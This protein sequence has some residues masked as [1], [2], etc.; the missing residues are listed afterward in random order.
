MH[1]KTNILNDEEGA[2]TVMDAAIALSL[3]VILT[4][5]FFTAAQNVHDPYEKTSINA[6]AIDIFETITNLPGLAG[7]NESN[8]WENDTLNVSR[9]GLGTDDLLMY[10]MAK[11]DGNGEI[12]EVLSRYKPSWSDYYWDEWT[13]F[14]AGTKVI[15]ADGSQK[16]IENI[17]IGDFVKSYDKNTGLVVPGE[18]SEVFYHSPEEMSDFYVIINGYLKVTSNHLLYSERDICDCGEYEGSWIKASELEVGDILFN[19]EGGYYISSIEWVYEKVITYNF[20][21]EEYHNY[22]VAMDTNDDIG[23][24]V[25]NDDPWIPEGCFPY[26]GGEPCYPTD[27]YFT[28][29]I[30]N[31][32]NDLIPSFTWYD[33]DGDDYRSRVMINDSGAICGPI[34]RLNIYGSMYNFGNSSQIISFWDFNYSESEGFRPSYSRALF[35][36]YKNR[37][38]PFMYDLETGPNSVAMQIGLRHKD[39]GGGYKRRA[40]SMSDTLYIQTVY[41]YYDQPPHAEFIAADVDDWGA[42]LTVG[43]DA[44]L[45]YDDNTSILNTLNSKI[46]KVEW[47]WDLE[48]ED[49]DNFHANEWYIESNMSGD[50]IYYH[51]YSDRIQHLAA[52]RVTDGIGQTTIFTDRVYG[53]FKSQMVDFAWWDIDGHGP[54]KTFFFDANVSDSHE[55]IKHYYW[56]FDGAGNSGGT[57]GCYQSPNPSPPPEIP[58]CEYANITFEY[59]ADDPAPH[60][61]YLF[62]QYDFGF[63]L[64]H[65]VKHVQEWPEPQ[66][67]WSDADGDGS[68]TIITFDPSKSLEFDIPNPPNVKVTAWDYDFDVPSPKYY[69]QNLTAAEIVTFMGNSDDWGLGNP[70]NVTHNYGDY[71]TYNA[72]MMITDQRGN[73]YVVNQ[74]VQAF[75]DPEPI[76]MFVYNS[77]IGETQI[78]FDASQSVDYTGPLDSTA[79]Y[80]NDSAAIKKYEWD[81][82]GDGIFEETY[83]YPNYKVMHDYGDFDWHEVTLKVWEHPTLRYPDGRNDTFTL[84]VTANETANALFTWYDKDGIGPDA[85]ITFNSSESWWLCGVIGLYLWDWDGDF[86]IRYIGYN[87]ADPSYGATNE[88]QIDHDF[89]LDNDTKANPYAKYWTGL[90]LWGYGFRSGLYDNVD[91][92]H[93]WVEAYQPEFSWSNGVDKT[94]HFDAS[95]SWDYFDDYDVNW[96]I[97]RIEWDW[98]LQGSNP[99]NFHADE[100]YNATNLTEGKT[101]NHNWGNINPHVVALRLWDENDTLS[102]VV[103]ETVT[104]TESPTFT[105]GFN[106]E[107][108]DGDGFGT[109]IDFSAYTNIGEWNEKK[110]GVNFT[111]D[112]TSD[113]DWDLTTPNRTVSYTYDSPDPHIVTL[114]INTSYHFVIIRDTVQASVYPEN[115]P[116]LSDDEDD[117]WNGVLTSKNDQLPD[118]PDTYIVFNQVNDTNYSYMIYKEKSSENL[119]LD[120]E[121]IQSLSDVPYEKFLESL[122]L[123]SYSFGIGIEISWYDDITNTNEIIRYGISPDCE[124][125]GSTFTKKAVIMKKPVFNSLWSVI[126]AH[127]FEGTITLKVIE[128]TMP[129]D[130]QNKP[131]EKPTTISPVDND[132]N[133]PLETQL[134]VDVIDPDGDDMTVNFYNAIDHSLF[135]TVLETPSETTA[136]ISVKNLENG[137]LY[138]WYVTID[139]GSYI[140]TSEIWSFTTV[141]FIENE[142]PSTPAI[143]TG[144]EYLQPNDNAPYFTSAVDP[145]NG[146]TVYYKFDWGDGSTSEWTTA[147]TV[148][149]SW[150]TGGTYTVKAM[151]KDDSEAESDWSDGLTVTV[152]SPPSQPTLKEPTNHLVGVDINTLTF[153]WDDCE[154]PEGN[155][156]TYM[157][158]LSEQNPPVY[159]KDVGGSEYSIKSP[160][161]PNTH[162][163]WKVVARDTH[164]A[165]SE[166]SVIWDFITKT[167]KK[168]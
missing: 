150:D 146:D 121:K 104:P 131:P 68:G 91:I 120:L 29:V 47:D 63:S 100:W 64:N 109:T 85:I 34:W 166:P 44:S 48:D 145:N 122:G 4:L 74:T 14:L 6:V 116:W 57:Y 108:A 133:I 12:E 143:P 19:L 92:G 96:T 147:E 65:I 50:G 106:W 117:Q 42:D 149:N 25:H 46:V 7:D 45:S 168:L 20:E 94:V 9:I 90:T 24:L 73:A 119:I 111:W 123:D 39:A 33:I 53:L 83:N 118:D 49:P 2:A 3:S 89:S 97:S 124:A 135:G 110:H 138:N 113:G 103:Y 56:D 163:Y 1:K 8:N 43:F 72:A 101:P 54:G 99:A 127:R 40:W 129:T 157:L 132:N 98:D 112:W 31:Y 41:G 78:Y 59:N 28:G 130:S 105:G 81:F 62:I 55:N 128:W 125:E 159:W 77:T 114:K 151:A 137:A 95:D 67:N 70:G 26:W 140:I 115:K 75:C 79:P 162:Y 152:N 51:N 102:Q 148:E 32:T 36:K 11:L 69:P 21:V 17:A 139:D 154:D 88:T 141:Q 167:V 153:D 27:G 16:N 52:L 107:D 22:F 5:V 136:S 23:I 87:P 71:N 134:Q 18:V 82:D 76:A 58:K 158:Y 80:A 156:I 13:C 37:R 38:E 35:D 161:K 66:F 86:R 93:D 84:T 61:V 165:E 60:S 144:S 15:M 155:S 126:H 142:P 30:V 160:L 10:G 164:G